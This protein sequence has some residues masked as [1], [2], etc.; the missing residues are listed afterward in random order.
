MLLGVAYHAA[1]S[2]AAGY[3]WLVQDASQSRGLY[4]FQAASHGFRMP[5]FFLISGFF[6]AM[7]WR[8]HGLRGLLSNRLRRIFLPCL[9]GLLTVVPA[10]NWLS[11][12]A[13]QLKIQRQAQRPAQAQRTDLWTAVT[14]GDA[15]AV[16]RAISEGSDPN[17]RHSQL[18]YTPLTA[19]ALL[20]HTRI[21]AALLDEG[22]RV[23]GRGSDGGTAL[24]A[25]AF[26]G[27]AD[28]AK[29]LLARGADP[30][31]RNSRGN[32]PK[33]AAS[34]D[35]PTTQVLAGFLR[36][37]LVREQVEAGRKQILEMLRGLGVPSAEVV[38]AL[39]HGPRE[40]VISGPWRRLAHGLMVT[41][42]FAHLWFLWF[43]CWLVG[44][45]TLYAL[46]AQWIGWKGPSSRW[47]LSPVGL[48]LPILI[49]LI[50]QGL[51]DASD[52]RFGPD[53]SI[54]ILPMPPVLLYYAVFFGFGV[55]YHDCGDSENRLGRGWRWTLPATLL[56]VFPPALEFGTGALGF[57][58]AWPSSRYYAPTAVFL[59]T[60]YAWCMS[61][62]CVGMFRS[63]L[64][65]ENR[66]IRYLSDSSYWLYL[67][68]LPLIIGAQM[69]I[70]DW[71]GAAGLKCLLLTLAVTAF[72]LLVYDK[73]VRYTWL[74]ALLNGP[75]AK[76]DRTRK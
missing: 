9:L 58:D 45:F 48:A 17:D 61:F 18:G 11:V 63:L 56:L 72:L 68:H 24:H 43:L 53:T 67:A 5:M 54:G 4:L 38:E 66:T 27:R 64:T 3:S 33:D 70:Q 12:K 32:T 31:A 49:T 50:P 65:R 46:V 36:I 73:A 8:K 30:A 1:L 40:N 57:R 41:P 16:S 60:L 23:N 76:P 47:L 15:D 39:A 28:A 20:G 71:Q 13:I 14:Q 44:G 34:V 69:A 6:T 7:M 29:V 22:A 26:L 19:A 25:A 55:L 42:F 62:S 74:G 2:F 37:E 59:Q 75:R 10:T 35:W 21:V 52:A 51:M